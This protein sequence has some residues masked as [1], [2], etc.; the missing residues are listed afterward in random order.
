MDHMAR[1]QKTSALGILLP[2]LFH[3]GVFALR[4]PCTHPARYFYDDFPKLSP[5]VYHYHMNPLSRPT[6]ASCLPNN[7]TNHLCT[8]LN[9][10]PQTAISSGRI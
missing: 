2:E 6:D 10:L 3:R 8:T 1:Q 9:R 4:V 7:A 5:R